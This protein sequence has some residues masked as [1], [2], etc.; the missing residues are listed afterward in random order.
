MYTCIYYPFLSKVLGMNWS[1]GMECLYR[2]HP[3]GGFVE[4]EFKSIS[5][6]LL[7]THGTIDTIM[8]L[9]IHAWN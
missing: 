3:T 4:A 8:H 2:S 9:P 7:I 6:R 1:R 5:Q